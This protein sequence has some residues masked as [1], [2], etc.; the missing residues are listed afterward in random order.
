MQTGAPG[1][2]PLSI[3]IGGALAILV[4]AGGAY[5]WSRLAPFAR[6][7]STYLAKQVCSCV[8]VAERP[9]PD[10]VDE[11]RPDS[12]KFSI[13]VDRAKLPTEGRIRTSFAGLIKGEARY[14]RGYGCT[15]VK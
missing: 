4:L 13:I 8:F 5:G 11:F 12:G 1:K 15:V 6:V 10:C 2:L 7:G 14:S 9:Y 3:W